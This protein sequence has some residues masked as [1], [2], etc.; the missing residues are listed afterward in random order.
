MFERACVLFN[1]AA[2]Y[3]QLAGA[4]DRSNPQ[5]VKRAKVYFEVSRHAL[6]S[7][8]LRSFLSLQSAAGT[9]SYLNTSVLP[10]F[11]LPDSEEDR[12]LDLTEPFIKSLELLMLAQAQECVW[13]RAVMGKIHVAQVG[14]DVT[15]HQYR[16]Q[17]EE[18][19]D[20]QARYSGIRLV[21]DT[22]YQ[23]R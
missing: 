18:R 21:I 6:A 2:L 10:K 22:H 19:R 15:H 1:L 20:S 4:E 13:Q 5:G 7:K 8:F 14:V 17:Y 11:S 16:R 3:S 23:N 9:L 12:P